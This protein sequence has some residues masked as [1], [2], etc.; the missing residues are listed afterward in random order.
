MPCSS[1]C[2]MVDEYMNTTKVP[3]DLKKEALSISCIIQPIRGEEDADKIQSMLNSVSV[4]NQVMPED[5]MEEQKRDPIL[6]L[7]CPYVTARDIW[8]SLAITKIK[9]KAVPKYLLQFDRLTFKQGVQHHQYINNNVEYHQMIL[10]IK[11][12]AQVLQMLHSGQ[13]HKGIRRTTALCREHFYWSTMC[14]HI[15]EYVKTCP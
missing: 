12:Q 9:S 6:G 10:P 14:K 13:G 8:K 11:F 5:M 4:L 3:D 2:E 7:V 1:V 15:A